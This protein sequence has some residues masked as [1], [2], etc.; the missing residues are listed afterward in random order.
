MGADEVPEEPEGE[1]RGA[2]GQQAS[3]FGTSRRWSFPA[4]RINIPT[5]ALPEST[6]KKFMAASGLAAQHVALS[7]SV[8]PI[9]EAHQGWKVQL[10]HIDSDIFQKFPL[11]HDYLASV[12]SQLI[13][14][15]DFGLSA[16]V[17]KIITEQFA[18]QQN[19][20]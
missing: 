8:R 7:N 1:D 16:S 13:Q 6:V 4:F 19:S 2:S 5:L 14:N 17:T 11:D 15:V 12:A 9:I 18:A 10:E 20:W 3:R